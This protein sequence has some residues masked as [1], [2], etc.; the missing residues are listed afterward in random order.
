MVEFLSRERIFDVVEMIG[1]RCRCLILDFLSFCSRRV[2]GW[3]L[4]VG[5]GTRKQHSANE[6]HLLA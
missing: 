1:L 4:L 3:H 2:F 6:I 5:P